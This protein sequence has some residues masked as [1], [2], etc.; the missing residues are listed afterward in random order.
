MF[1][2]QIM[3]A[4]LVRTDPDSSIVKPAHIHITSAPQIRKEK[5][6]RT[7]WV[8][9]A[10]W[11]ATATGSAA[12]RA[13]A[14]SAANARRLFRNCL[15]K[16]RLHRQP[17]LVGGWVRIIA[18]ARLRFRPAFNTDI[19]K[20]PVR[21]LRPSNLADRRARGSV[22]IRSRPRRRN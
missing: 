3:A 9:A 18:A 11:A 8:S 5:V 6:F 22:S 17:L 21:N 1:L 20:N 10:T 15:L 19:A 12:S 16:Q 4:F 14:T 13:T 2:R 7:N